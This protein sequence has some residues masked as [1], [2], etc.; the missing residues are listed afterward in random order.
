MTRCV[1]AG[2]FY[3]TF[4]LGAWDEDGTDDYLQDSLWWDFDGN[5]IA[6]PLDP[7]WLHNRGYDGETGSG[8]HLQIEFTVVD[9]CE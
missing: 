2:T 5:T 3:G 7:F 9:G 6:D 4:F 8:G 1:P